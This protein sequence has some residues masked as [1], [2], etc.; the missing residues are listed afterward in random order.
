MK[1]I[2]LFITDCCWSGSSSLIIELLNTALE[3]QKR[4]NLRLAYSIDLIGIGTQP[5]KTFSGQMLQAQFDIA[6]HKQQYDCICLPN[7]WEIDDR[8]LTENAPLYPWL[9]Q[10]YQAGASVYGFVTGAFLMAEA[11]ILDGRTATT[12]WHLADEFRSRYPKVKLSSVEMLTAHQR[13]YCCGGINATMDMSMHIIQEYCGPVIAQQCEKHC[14]MGTRRNYL[15]VNIDLSQY[16]THDDERVLAIQNWLEKHYA[17]PI[18]LEDVA[19]QFGFSQRN[20]NRRFKQA[21]NQAPQKYLQLY[22]MEVAKELLRSS[23][24]SIQQVCYDSG[25]DSLTV[26]GRRFKQYTS[27]S[28]SA[29]K[30]QHSY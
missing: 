25:Y 30:R 26:F 11:G 29:F 14:M 17:E 22:R 20:L 15:R 9:R 4:Q 6:S 10:Q 5:V 24:L 28:P 16:K 19:T 7:I 1:K 18:S 21:V 3:F 23:S 13:L 2:A 27:L 8:K 12:H